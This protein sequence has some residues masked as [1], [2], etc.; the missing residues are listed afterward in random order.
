MAFPQPM[1]D[2]YAPPA[3]SIESLHSVEIN[4]LSTDSMKTTEAEKKTTSIDSLVAAAATTSMPQPHRVSKFTEDLEGKT[5]PYLERRDSAVSK[6]TPI[7]SAVNK[8]TPAEQNLKRAETKSSSRLTPGAINSWYRTKLWVKGAPERLRKL[9]YGKKMK[10]KRWRDSAPGVLEVPLEDEHEEGEASDYNSHTERQ[11]RRGGS[12]EITAERMQG[13]YD[14]ARSFSEIF[15]FRVPATLSTSAMFPITNPELGHTGLSNPFSDSNETFTSI[16]SDS[17]DQ[18]EDSEENHAFFPTRSSSD[19]SIKSSEESWGD[20]TIREQ[21]IA[22]GDVSSTP[23]VVFNETDPLAH[24]AVFEEA[25]GSVESQVFLP[26]SRSS[27][28]MSDESSRDGNNKGLEETWEALDEQYP[29]GSAADLLSFLRTLRPQGL[30]RTQRLHADQAYFQGMER[31]NEVL[32]G[33][34]KSKAVEEFTAHIRSEVHANPHLLIAYAWTLYMAIFSGGRWIRAQLHG[35]GKDFWMASSTAPADTRHVVDEKLTLENLREVEDLGLS[36]W[37]FDGEQDGEDIK[38]E[39]KR[40]L[41]DVEPILT[42]AQRDDIMLES[43]DIFDRFKAMV[44]DLDAAF[45]ATCF[46]RAPVA[47]PA[48]AQVKAYKKNATEYFFDV[49]GYAG[50]ALVISGVSCYAMY[51]AGTWS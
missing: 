9:V 42:P 30:A 5:I 46:D 4:V 39:F 13:R 47:T 34:M 33:L 14:D 7:L 2:S 21:S 44:D 26:A 51:H 6:T 41:N 24:S 31:A 29:N 35:A 8:S 19:L 49:P 50:L 28:K 1:T 18:V 22:H 15:R 27:P 20:M 32:R 48:T 45:Q 37:F 23:V 10:D 36:L 3:A 43:Q 16:R 11:E 40:R 17:D 38:V 25:D 12:L